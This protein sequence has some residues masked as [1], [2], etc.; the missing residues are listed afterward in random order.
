MR[1]A[2]RLRKFID[3]VLTGYDQAAKVHLACFCAEGDLL[4]QWRGYGAVGGGYALGMMTKNLGVNVLNPLAEHP[5]PILRKVIYSPAVQT[6]IISHWARTLCRLTRQRA[7]STTTRERLHIFEWYFGRFLAECLNC[8]K[9]PAY[10]AEQE[11]RLIQFAEWG[12]RELRNVEFRTTGPRIV[13][14]VELDVTPTRGAYKGKLPIS[15]I[16]YGP[17]LDPIVTERSLRLFCT[18]QGYVV[19][20]RDASRPPTRSRNSPSVTIKRSGVP[21]NG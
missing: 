13:P 14:Y 9:D 15:I 10:E 12:G 2:K 20:H 21:F 17:T 5:K 7:Y 4:S 6:R 3:D 8:F 19:Q 18:A 16:R 11:W 1:Q